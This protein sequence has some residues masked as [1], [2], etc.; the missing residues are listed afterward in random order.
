M[1]PTSNKFQ[2]A[3][4]CTPCVPIFPFDMFRYKVTIR[5][6]G[7]TTTELWTTNYKKVAQIYKKPA[8]D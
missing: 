7:L 5:D 4:T 8:T 1:G 6:F 3:D 2:I